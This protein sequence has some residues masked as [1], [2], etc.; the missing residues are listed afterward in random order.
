MSD[1]V[2]PE[3][4]YDSKNPDSV[5]VGWY[6]TLYCWD[7]SEGIFAGGNRWLGDRWENELP[8]FAWVGPFSTMVKADEW[9]R[10]HN[11]EDL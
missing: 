1:P 8:V 5:E 3:W 2:E 9:A 4:D 11:P 6:A 7:T 10:A